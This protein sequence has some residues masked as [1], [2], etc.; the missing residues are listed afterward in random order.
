M[1]TPHSLVLPLTTFWGEVEL[2]R[3]HRCTVLSLTTLLLF[4]RHHSSV[5]S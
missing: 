2:K 1:L 5:L 4:F 3:D